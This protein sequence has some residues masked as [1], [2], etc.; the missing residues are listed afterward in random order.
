MIEGMQDI[1]M[2]VVYQCLGLYI[3]N[4]II[5]TRMYE[6]HVTDFKKVLQGLEEPK[7]YLKESKCQFFITKLEIPGQIL[8][9][10]GL[11]GDPNKRK[12]NLEFPT[13]ACKN[14]LG[15]FLGVANDLQ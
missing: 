6:E 7:F 11:Y 14:T 9:S 13:P 5:Y 8:T 10:D 1:F 4:I 2:V 3:N 15:G 12:T